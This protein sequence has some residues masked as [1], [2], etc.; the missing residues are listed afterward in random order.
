MECTSVD[1]LGSSAIPLLRMV[2]GSS[3]RL[4]R[5]FC[6]WPPNLS[7]GPCILVCRYLF[8]CRFSSVYQSPR[9]SITRISYY[10]AVVASACNGTVWIVGCRRARS[11]RKDYG[12]SSP[13]G[14][15]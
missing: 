11:S 12:I 1:D 6:R 9:E 7:L 4:S 13:V 10:G 5:L 2:S 8:W 3:A 15:E 14:T